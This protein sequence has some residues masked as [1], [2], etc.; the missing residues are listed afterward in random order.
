MSATISII[1]PVLNEVNNIENTC[2]KANE[3]ADEVIVVDGGSTDGTLKLLAELPC[4]VVQT[5]QG[6][7]QQLS[8]GADCAEGDVL[9]FLHADTWLPVEARSQI[10]DAIDSMPE[11]TLNRFCGFFKQTIDGS[12]IIYRLIE[13][14]NL[15]RGHF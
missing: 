11:E 10:L 15:W 7:G 12:G 9:L 3:I 6:R 8:A 5:A 1:I 4:R 2:L 13:K 14:G